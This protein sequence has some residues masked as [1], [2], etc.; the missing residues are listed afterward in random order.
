MNKEQEKMFDPASHLIGIWFYVNDYIMG[1]T[2]V[3]WG[4]SIIKDGQYLSVEGSFEDIWEK[5]KDKY[6]FPKKKSYKDYA[7]GKVVFDTTKYKYI[8]FI[9]DKH[10]HQNVIRK[11]VE[12]KFNL[13]DMATKYEKLSVY[14]NSVKE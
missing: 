2:D 11:K 10:F 7:H 8:V 9:D 5:D 14:G 3:V 1:P 12:K 4:D 13:P 6:Y